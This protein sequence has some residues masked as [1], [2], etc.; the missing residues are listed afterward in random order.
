MI[1]VRDELVSVDGT[2]AM[3]CVESFGGWGCGWV[4]GGG[5]GGVRLTVPQICLWYIFVCVAQLVARSP[6][7]L[8]L[9]WPVHLLSSISCCAC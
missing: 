5:E 1:L 9:L 7:L 4:G 6:T 8:H 3:V 2:P